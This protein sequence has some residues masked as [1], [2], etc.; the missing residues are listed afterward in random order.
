MGE[1]DLKQ[2]P[3]PRE[4]PVLDTSNLQNIAGFKIG[5]GSQVIVAD[6]EGQR[7]GS[8]LF[9]DAKAWIKTDGSY[10]FKSTDGDVILDS[11]NASGDFI[12]IINTALNTSSKKILTGFTF[13]STDYA[14]ALK[15]GDVTWNASTG[16]PT[17]GTGF[18]INA[19][20]IIGVN[21][22]A[23]TVSILND[24][25]ATFAGTLSAPNGTLGTL[26][27]G[28]LTG[29]TI[30]TRSSGTRVVITNNEYIYFKDGETNKGL[31]YTDGSY[32]MN[33]VGTDDVMFHAGGSARC[34]VFSSSMKP[35]SSGSYDLGTDANRWGTVHATAYYAAG[36]SG[37][38]FDQGFVVRVNQS[39]SGGD[40]THLTA[41]EIKKRTISCIGGIV[42]TRGAESDWEP[43]E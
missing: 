41:V 8:H 11:E 21:G 37:E 31:I 29:S 12:N 14:G 19:K 42:T 20:G 13:E 23:T 43:A 40:G 33:I 27:G 18:I 9:D 24:G 36:D 10:K 39:K 26:T 6:K 5:A 34:G 15:T 30:Q 22:G 17:G 25:T 1:F 3:L 38:T 4:N 28:T 35:T 32:D 2:Q 16:L 7:F